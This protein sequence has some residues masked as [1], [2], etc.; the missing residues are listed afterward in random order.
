MS[1]GKKIMF[2]YIVFVAGI[3]FLVYKSSSQKVDLVT[4]D[5]YKKELAFQHTIE[6][7]ERVNALSG[8]T[9]FCQIDSELIITLPKEMMNKS[10]EVDATLYCPSDKE[11]DIH[12]NTSTSS[13]KFKWTLSLETKGYFEIHLRWI[14][15]QLAFYQEDKLFIK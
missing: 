5:Y 12:F 11:K 6:E 9:S 15:D 1:W 2:V 4:P 13:G 14:A 10:V 8:K 3:L 7:R